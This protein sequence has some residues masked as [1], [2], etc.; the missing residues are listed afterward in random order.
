MGDSKN[1]KTT[2]Q[3]HEKPSSQDRGL[4]ISSPI[5]ITDQQ[6]YVKQSNLDTQELRSSLLYWDNLAL[7]VS[8]VIHIDG[9]VEADYLEKCGILK[10]RRYSFTSGGAESLVL[11]QALTL[12]DL[13]SESPGVWSLGSGQNSMFI[14]GQ[15]ADPDQGTLLQLYNAIPVPKEDTPL[16][17]ILEFKNKRKT[18][19]LTFREHMEQLSKEISSSNDSIDELNLKLKLLD[20]ACSDLI[21][22]T[23][24]YQLP[25]YIS[26]LNASLNFDYKTVGVAVATWAG[27]NR[28]GMD[29]TTSTVA[30]AAATAASMIALKSDIKF[31]NFKRTASPFKYA[32]YIQRDL[33]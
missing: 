11:A 6:I 12:K 2:D 8:N 27:C 26:N 16:S 20:E 25:F 5:E 28:L 7:P 4:I 29:N 32:Y 3:H 22:T 23:R 17:D 18:E 21:K 13:E 14:K 10:R 24:E 30:T 33:G 31:R 9:G 15:V 1:R 19:L